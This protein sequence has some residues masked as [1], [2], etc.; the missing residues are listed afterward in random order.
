MFRLL[1]LS[2]NFS[3]FGLNS[4]RLV[5][6]LTDGFAGHYLHK[7]KDRVGYQQI[8]DYGVWCD[9]LYPEFPTLS[10]PNH[11]SLMTGENKKKIL[12]LKKNH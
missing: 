2:I 12:M 7:I 3:V 8:I 9:R 4:A 1:F 11:Y 5:L 10:L 6:L